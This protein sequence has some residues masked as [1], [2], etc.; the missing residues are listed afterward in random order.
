M[1]EEEG[2]LPVSFEVETGLKRESE[3]EKKEIVKKKKSGA[4]FS[5]WGKKIG[6]SF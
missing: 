3:K 4:S 1:S 5:I 2:D 6:R